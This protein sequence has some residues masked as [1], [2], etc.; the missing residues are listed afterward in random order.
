MVATGDGKLQIDG[1]KLLVSQGKVG[2]DDDCCCDPVNKTATCDDCSGSDCC[3][4]LHADT[5][6]D[7]TW[8]ITNPSHDGGDGCGDTC[9]CTTGY[10]TG[11]ETLRQS[12]SSCE[13]SRRLPDVCVAECPLGILTEAIL[14]CL[15]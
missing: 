5:T 14:T 10:M 7:A 11:S 3:F 12:G 2:T 9:R 1:G 4:S 13:Y 6:V 15:G 8:A